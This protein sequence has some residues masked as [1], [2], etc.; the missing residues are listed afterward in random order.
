M[1]NLPYIL[2]I[3]ITFSP[4]RLAYQPPDNNAFLS[5]QT[6]HQQLVSSIFLS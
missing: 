1:Y 6:N 4:V 5:E 2:S 3:S